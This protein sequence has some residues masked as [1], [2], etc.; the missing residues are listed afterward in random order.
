MESREIGG[1]LFVY[2]K[3]G[4]TKIIGWRAIGLQKF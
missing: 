3:Q 4:R 2:A 1:W